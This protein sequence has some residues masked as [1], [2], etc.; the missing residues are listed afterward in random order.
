MTGFL[1]EVLLSLVGGPIRG[2]G[3]GGGQGGSERKIEVIVR[4]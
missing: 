1:E 3:G 2:G 4:I